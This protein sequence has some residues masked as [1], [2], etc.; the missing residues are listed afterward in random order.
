MSTARAKGLM[1]CGTTSDAG[2]SLLV[3]ALCRHFFRKGIRVAPFKAQNMALNA[4][5]AP[6]GGEMGVA[7]A[8]QAE[9]CGLEPD[10]R[11]NPVLL[12]PQGDSTSQVVLLGRPAATLSARD[13]HGRNGKGYAA[14]AW[15]TARD[16]LAAL[17]EEYDLLLLEGAGSP[18]EMN[19]YAA[20]FTNL[21]TAREAEAPVLLVGDIERGGVLA[22]LVG[23]LAVLP[24][25]DAALIK[26][27]AVNKFRGDSSLFDEGCRFLEARTGRPVL[28][29]LP[30][31]THLRLPAEDSLGLRSFGDGP[32]RIVVIKLPRIANFT[33]FDALEHD[34]CRVVFADAPGDLDGA[35]CIVLPGTKAT[36]ADLR[37][38]RQR[39]LA[40]ALRD[41]ADRGIPLWGICGGYQMLGERIDDPG[42][43][44]G[45]GPE[46]MEG[47]GLLPVRTFFEGTKIAAPARAVVNDW[48]PGPWEAL[49]DREISGYEIHMGR[50]IPVAAA[51]FGDGTPLLTLI[52]R[53]GREILE[54]DG[55]ARPDGTVF[56]C[57][58]HGLADDPLF[59]RAFVN[60]LRRRKGLAPLGGT[61]ETAPSGRELRDRS[62]DA[63]ADFVAAH[64]DMTRL[65]ELIARGL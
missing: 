46:S 12:K 37:W 45:S 25:K 55:A 57:Y 34:G 19:I 54:A 10:V 16:A 11:F 65:E 56:G 13:Y 43:V 50:T 44:E 27:F 4:Y 8:L 51:S 35:D 14:T 49:R 30:Y 31:A 63:W 58:L 40:T 61:G 17:R 33:D 48:A 59:R 38:L 7:Q 6:G 39:G 5:T 32:L 26:A 47:L 2:K 20:D 36:M 52:A 1:V 42:G 18:A 60:W 22:S 15:E 53:G 24:E 23:T 9:A 62:Y 64:L 41:A 28:G 21:R 29:V 3:T